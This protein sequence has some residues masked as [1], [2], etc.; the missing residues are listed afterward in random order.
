MYKLNSE[1]KYGWGPH[2]T[3]QMRKFW[4]VWGGGRDKRTQRVVVRLE[5]HN[6]VRASTGPMDLS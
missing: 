1:I 2:S 4:H 6:Q 3:S 5:G